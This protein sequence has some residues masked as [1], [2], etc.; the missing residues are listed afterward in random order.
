MDGA[1][2]QQI[3][4]LPRLVG[5]ALC[6]IVDGDRVAYTSAPPAHSEQVYTMPGICRDQQRLYCC[7][8]LTLP[9]ATHDRLK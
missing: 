8:W 4:L 7:C 1:C 5:L 6:C 2:D 3:R 9:Y